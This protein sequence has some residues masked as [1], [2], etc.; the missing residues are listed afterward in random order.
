MKQKLT[1][2]TFLG[3]FVYLV[4]L[5]N[6]NGYPNDVSG[7]TA[8]TSGCNAGGNCHG[9]AATTLD[10]TVELDSAGV[11]VS[12]Y[13]PG[14]SYTVKITAK[15]FG[16][17]TKFGYQ[18]SCVKATGAGTASA[19]AAGTWGTLPVGSKKVSSSSPAVGHGTILG[20][21]N[22]AYT[23]IIPWTAPAKGTGTVNLYGILNAL[24]NQ[25][26]NAWQNTPVVSIAERSSPN[27]ISQVT[28]DA[29][30]KLY[31]SPSQGVF[32]LE[33]PHADGTELVIT[34]LAG[35]IVHREILTQDKQTI[36]TSNL[37]PQLYLANVLYQGKNHPISFQIIK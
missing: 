19:V 14:Q 16:A 6:S 3:L 9:A 31:P 37:S 2:S 33:C 13:V 15:Q 27:S 34:D 18:V 30:I 20:V 8:S 28:A 22:N 24:A 4:V 17:F 36:H 7:S 29:G 21:A 10:P 11:S 25:G 12:G 32:T 5:A 35:R 23:V 26:S 1:L